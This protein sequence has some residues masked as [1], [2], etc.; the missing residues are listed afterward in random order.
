MEVG[1]Q[2]QASRAMICKSR[3]SPQQVRLL[4]AASV[5]EKTLVT[6]CV[7]SSCSHPH[8]LGKL[9]QTLPFTLLSDGVDYSI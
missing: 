7:F 3:N 9:F 5:A 1:V 2:Q 8:F 4:A 6:A